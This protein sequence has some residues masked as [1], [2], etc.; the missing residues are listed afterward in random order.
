MR[1]IRPQIGTPKFNRNNIGGNSVVSLTV[2]PTL[3][4]SDSNT[5]TGSTLSHV[6]VDYAHQQTRKTL[7][8]QESTHMDAM[9][10]QAVDGRRLRQA[11]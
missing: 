3:L 4:N 7:S 9:N 2:V 1:Y 6:F 11:A 8:D 5:L 10:N